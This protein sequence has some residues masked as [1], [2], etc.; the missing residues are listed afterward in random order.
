M[1]KG[2]AF[3]G[4]EFRQFSPA[5]PEQYYVYREG[6]RVAYVR[7]GWGFLCYHEVVDGKGHLGECKMVKLFDD[8]KLCFET[9]KERDVWL[10]RIANILKKK[11][12][13]RRGFKTT[14]RK[15]A[16]TY[17]NNKQGG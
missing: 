17:L 15:S 12:I 6:K 16:G 4:Y 5:A 11:G 2:I 10:K 13:G 3:G 8:A 14:K 1:K 7:L 9:A